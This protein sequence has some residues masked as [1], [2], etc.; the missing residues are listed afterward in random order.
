MAA[1]PPTVLGRAGRQEWLLLAA[2]TAAAGW[3]FLTN[4]GDQCL[5]Q[6]EAQT[7][8]IAKTVLVD[9]LPHVDDGRNS[10]SQELGHESY[11]PRHLYRWH[12]WFPFYWLAAFFGAFGVNTFVARLPFALLGWTTVPIAY[13]LGRSLWQ[14]RRAAALG[15]VLLATCVPFLVLS[16]QCRYYSPCMAFAVLALLAYQR[17]TQRKRWAATLFVVAAVLLFH[18]QHLYWG[19]LL[20]TVLVHAAI[21]HRDRLV[22]VAAASLG[23]LL[24]NLPWLMWLLSPPMVGQYPDMKFK[25]ISPWT[26]ANQY[27]EQIYLQVFSPALVALLL[28]VAVVAAVRTRSLPKPNR[29]SLRGASLVLLFVAWNVGLCSVLTPLYFFRYLAPA[30]PL[31]CVLA[32]AVLDAAMRLHWSL[33]ILGLVVIWLTSPLTDYFHELTQ[34]YVGPID[35]IVA[36]LNAH[37]TPDDVVAISYED[38]PLKFHTKMRVVGGLTGEDLTPALRA[39][40]IILRHNIIIPSRDGAVWQY[41]A[42]HLR[43]SESD[44]VAIPLDCPDLPFNNREDPAERYRTETDPDIPPVILYRRNSPMP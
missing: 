16:R 20:A 13:F 40:W 18:S 38:L 19:V 11:G 14:S 12:T 3:L 32:A 2:L 6:D 44:Y 42:G 4:L 36:Y 21:F 35:G 27:L 31:L 29:N 26:L 5:W 23:T 17:M 34:Q 10:F 43:R 41:L 24:L 25:P 39:D 28:V 8:L 15:A 22:A 33:G 9:G 7:A 30:I 37:G 1:V